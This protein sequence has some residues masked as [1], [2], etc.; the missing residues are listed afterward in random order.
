MRLEEKKG[1]RS[2]RH[3]AERC[4]ET[5][6]YLYRRPYFRHRHYIDYRQP[7]TV[8]APGVS[9]QRRVPRCSIC[10]ESLSDRNASRRS[11]PRREMHKP[12]CV[13]VRVTPH[14]TCFDHASLHHLYTISLFLLYMVCVYTY[15]YISNFSSR[16]P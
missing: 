11:S 8:L 15:T 10:R 12:R 9:V 4:D 14:M 5:V 6:V 1:E 13:Y 7:A 3:P 16:T 2:P